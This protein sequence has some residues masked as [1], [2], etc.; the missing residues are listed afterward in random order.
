MGFIGVNYLRRKK[1]GETDGTNDIIYPMQVM[2]IGDGGGLEA[3]YRGEDP[4]KV[5][6][7]SVVGLDVSRNKFA[8]RPGLRDVHA[9]KG[10]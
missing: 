2:K 1:G 10:E 4:L 5:S 6:P 9:S 3:P 7:V 8:W